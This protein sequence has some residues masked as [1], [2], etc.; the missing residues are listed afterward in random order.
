M[1]DK[2]SIFYALYYGAVSPWENSHLFSSQEYKDTLK[3]ATE[4]QEKLLEQL[5]EDSKKLLD[6][7]LKADAKVGSFFEEEKFKDGFILG[8][9]LMIETLSDKRYETKERG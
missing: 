8:A 1:L 6:E 5:N 4:L 7:F 9:R 2:N 3:L